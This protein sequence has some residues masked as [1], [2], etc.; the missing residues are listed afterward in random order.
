[1]KNSKTFHLFIEQDDLLCVKCPLC[2]ISQLFL[3]E[4]IIGNGIMLKLVL[5]SEELGQEQVFLGLKEL[6]EMGLNRND[7]ERLQRAWKYKQ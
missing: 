1:M 6:E 4:Q 2:K 5:G 7:V 3:L